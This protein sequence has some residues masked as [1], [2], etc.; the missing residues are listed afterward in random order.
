MG[1]RSGFEGFL[2]ATA[3]AVAAAERERQRGIRAQLTQAR[4]IERH[5][6][7]ALAQQN[8]DDRAAQKIAKAQYL[9]LFNTSEVEDIAVFTH[10]HDHH[11]DLHGDVVDDSAP[12]F[13]RISATPAGHVHGPGCNHDH[14]HDHAGHRHD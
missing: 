3:R 2:R 5:Q 11:H 1:R 6:R 13:T 14:G 12:R 4:Q 9:A 10:K 8:R 7:M